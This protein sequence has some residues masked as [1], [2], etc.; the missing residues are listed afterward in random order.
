MIE[1]I[2]YKLAELRIVRGEIFR[3]NII[4]SL[5]STRFNKLK[6]KTIQNV[7]GSQEN[8]IELVLVFTSGKAAK[9]I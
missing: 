3:K 6:N 4:Y 7:L 8:F 9:F 5:T 2:L 1:I